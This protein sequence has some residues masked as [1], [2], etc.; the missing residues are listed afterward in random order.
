MN[1]LYP[2]MMRSCLALSAVV[3]IVMFGGCSRGTGDSAKT[4]ARG[5]ASVA[6]ADFDFFSNDKSLSYLQQG[7]PVP[8][9]GAYSGGS[10]RV[11][12][13]EASAIG[14][15]TLAEGSSGRFEL[16]GGLRAWWLNTEIR[17]DPGLLP[18][19]TVD[20]TT[21]WVDPVIAARASLRLNDRLSLTGY[22]DIGGFGVGSE[23]TWQV[24]ATLDWRVSDWISASLGYRWIQIEYEDRRATINLDMSGP[25]LGA[26]FRF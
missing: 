14:L 11:K 23:F 5:R 7:V 24:V 13:T 20:Q 25:I 3:A 10:S 17:L 22:G 6:V 16:G 8:G 21:N 12:T 18:G 4:P 2:A 15:I 19:R 9:E 26:S 1:V